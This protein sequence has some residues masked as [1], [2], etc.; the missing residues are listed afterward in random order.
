MHARV[1]NSTVHFNG[2]AVRVDDVSWT[3]CEATRTSSSVRSLSVHAAC[4]QP[5]CS[6]DA[7]N[8]HQTRSM[9][10]ACTQRAHSIL[11]PRSMHILHPFRI[12]AAYMRWHAAHTQLQRA[13]SMHAVSMQY[14][15]SAHAAYMQHARQVHSAVRMP[16]GLRAVMQRWSMVDVVS[17]TAVDMLMVL[18]RRL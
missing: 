12:H 5:T 14:K 6:I 11:H 2:K 4:V 13:C 1:Q 3:P 16:F 7:A 10:A 8:V 17:K 15:R 18:K 9:H